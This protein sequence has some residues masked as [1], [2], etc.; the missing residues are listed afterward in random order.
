MSTM[1]PTIDLTPVVT[2]APDGDATVARALDGALRTWGAFTLVG[3]GVPQ[4]ALEGALA[5]AKDFFAQPL[6]R[7]LAIKVDKNNRGYVPIH[8]SVYEGNLPDLKESFN[9]G[10]PLPTDDPDVVAGK[11]LHGANIWPDLPGYRAPVETFFSEMTR[12]GERLLGPLA[13]CLGM[14][15]DELRAHYRKPITFMR[16][17]H[18]PPNSRVADGEHGAAEHQDYGFLTFL[19]QDTLGGL[20]VRAPDGSIVDV[21][22]RLDTFTVNVGDMLARITGG[23]FRSAPHKVINI[24]G[25]GRYS[26]PFFYDPNFDARFSGYAR[27]ECWP[28]P[29]VEI[30]QGLRLSQGSR[31]CVVRIH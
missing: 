23:A 22:P 28:I 2:G 25:K 26:I 14:A 8:Q 31:G 1:L 30:Q 19:A 4:A 7:R 16:L 18:Y 24:S 9:L 29:A 3:H 5:A 6:E 15:P 11:P 21:T 12:L 17:F 27:Y 10:L 20:Q 13:I